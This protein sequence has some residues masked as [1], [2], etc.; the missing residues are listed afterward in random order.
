[1]RLFL[2]D[3]TL[4]QIETLGE[5][6]ASLNVTVSREQLPTHCGFSPVPS[7]S[8]PSR[9]GFSKK[10]QVQVHKTGRHLSHPAA[11]FKIKEDLRP[12]F[13]AHKVILSGNMKT[14][15]NGEF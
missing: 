2:G 11:V 12:A 6:I 9:I 10:L 4:S 5:F 1:M 14:N 3:S 15:G 8:A 13:V 7:P